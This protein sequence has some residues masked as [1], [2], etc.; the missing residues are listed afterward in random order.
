MIILSYFQ[1]RSLH[2]FSLLLAGLDKIWVGHLWKRSFENLPKLVRHYLSLLVAWQERLCLVAASS[3]IHKEVFGLRR[4][5]CTSTRLG[6]RQST[7]PTVPQSLHLETGLPRCFKTL[8]V[9]LSACLSV[10]FEFL[11]RLPATLVVQPWNVNV[12]AL[13]VHHLVFF[14]CIWIAPK[15]ER[16]YQMRNWVSKQ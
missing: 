15:S 8:S 5:L 9:C 1:I 6:D 4:Y 12:S 13:D 7:L 2:A 16:R 11:A 14:L 10:F 3:K